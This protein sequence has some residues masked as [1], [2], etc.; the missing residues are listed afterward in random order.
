V[1]IEF[2]SQ[3][4]ASFFMTEPV[5]QMVFRAIGQELTPQGIF[6]KEQV[7]EVR[8]RLARAIAQTRPQDRQAIDR[9]ED[10]LREGETVSEELPI[11]LSQ[12]AFPLLDMLLAAE[13]EQAAVVWG[14]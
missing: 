7:P 1:I 14:V 12:R 8:A 2:K 10:A 13:K 5:A 9:H 4:A 3:A 6:T 11:G